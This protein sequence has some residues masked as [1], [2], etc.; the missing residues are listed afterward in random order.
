[1]SSCANGVSFITQPKNCKI[2]KN[3][4]A[5]ADFQSFRDKMKPSN[6]VRRT[7]SVHAM[8]NIRCAFGECKID[9]S[10]DKMTCVKKNNWHSKDSK[11]T[12]RSANIDRANSKITSMKS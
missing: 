12:L 9:K 2:V 8:F 11:S 4:F 5:G 6:S 10:N 3:A 1:M 7:V